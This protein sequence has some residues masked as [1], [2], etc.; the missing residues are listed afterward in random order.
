MAALEA[1]PPD[2]V[3]VVHRKYM[4][5]IGLGRFGKSARFGKALWEWVEGRYP[6]VEVIG[7]PPFEGEQFGV[8]LRTKRP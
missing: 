8:A 1:S 2:C 3:L 6:R 4:S 5:E 7:S